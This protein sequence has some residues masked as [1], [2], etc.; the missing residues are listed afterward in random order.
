MILLTDIDFV[1]LKE[2]V[3]F[4]LDV[5]Y[6]IHHSPEEVEAV[7]QLLQICPFVFSNYNKF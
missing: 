4:L 1:C 2:R 6:W 7:I 5:N 3:Q